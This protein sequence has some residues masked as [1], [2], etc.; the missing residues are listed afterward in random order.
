M[1][2]V[3]RLVRVAGVLAVLATGTQAALA[4]PRSLQPACWI[5]TEVEG[6]LYCRKVPCS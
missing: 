5:C 1:Q 3:T 6:I 2:K 4:A